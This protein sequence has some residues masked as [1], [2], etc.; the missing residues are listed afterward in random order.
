LGDGGVRRQAERETELAVLTPPVGVP[1]TQA[2]ASGREDA[3]AAPAACRCVCG[4]GRTAH[5][6]YR[7]GSDCGICGAAKCAAYRQPG[8]ILRRL[9]GRGLG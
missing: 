7:R 5:R 2:T 6:H 1:V 9:L 4:H 8:G 3:R